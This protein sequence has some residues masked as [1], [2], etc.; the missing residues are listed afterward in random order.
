M[1]NQLNDL[2]EAVANLTK[3]LAQANSE[4]DMVQEVLD[5][6]GLRVACWV[7]NSNV[8]LTSGQLQDAK[9]ALIKHHPND[10]DSDLAIQSGATGIE[11]QLGFCEIE[12]ELKAERHWRLAVRA[13]PGVTV[14]QE[15]TALREAPYW[16]RIRAAGK[17]PQLI[18]VLTRLAK[19][20]AIEVSELRR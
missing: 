11:Y 15:P 19:L 4:I 14:E 18:S 1:E 6:S 10:A 8:R 5:A 17:L 3:L 7:T 9:D 12:D 13:I 16:V 2:R 20:L